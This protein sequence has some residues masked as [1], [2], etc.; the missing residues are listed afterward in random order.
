MR[1][2]NPSGAIKTVRTEEGKEGGEVDVTGGFLDHVFEVGG[3]WV[4]A[5]GGEHTG[6]IVLGDESVTILVDHVEGFLEL[7]DLRLTEQREDVGGG[8]ER[9]FS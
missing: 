3:W 2:E 5:H 1:L 4:F 6:Q 7:L 8:L 9:E